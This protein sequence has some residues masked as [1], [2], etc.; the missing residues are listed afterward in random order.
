VPK[1]RDVLIP[2]IP[3]PDMLEGLNDRAAYAARCR[4]VAG[5]RVFENDL[6]VTDP[7]TAGFAVSEEN[8]LRRDLFGQ[9]QQ[10]RRIPT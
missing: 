4:H 3:R 9:P 7:H 5:G 10:I 8:Y 6:Q 1:L 2:D